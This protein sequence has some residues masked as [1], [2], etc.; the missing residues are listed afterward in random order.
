MFVSE[1]FSSSVRVF[2]FSPRFNCGV[3]LPDEKPKAPMK[4]S[5]DAPAAPS[6]IAITPEL[7]R[8]WFTL[9]NAWNMSLPAFANTLSSLSVKQANQLYDV[10][11]VALFR[12]SY[13]E[14]LHEH[15]E[16]KPL[17]FSDDDRLFMHDIYE[18][19][20]YRLDRREPEPQDLK[21]ARGMKGRI[22]RGMPDLSG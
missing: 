19:L 22:G 15:P 13:A 18:N 11:K 17:I 10:V 3:V 4:T 21:L 2:I 14:I 16:L 1:S 8:M 20:S 5:K 7:R 9:R 6:K 12:S